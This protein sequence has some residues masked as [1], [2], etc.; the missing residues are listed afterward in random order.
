MK[1][2]ATP[3]ISA[4]N[5]AVGLFAAHTLFP[6]P[7]SASSNMEPYAMSDEVAPGFLAQQQQQQSTSA[8]LHVP[9]SPSAGEDN[10]MDLPLPSQVQPS[11]RFSGRRAILTNSNENKQQNAKT[12]G[13]ATVTSQPTSSVTSP[14][15]AKSPLKSSRTEN[16]SKTSYL[17]IRI[18]TK[19]FNIFAS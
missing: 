6:A 11:L 17:K 18:K 4:A 19:Y 7:A 9:V 2:T 1:V 16:S 15:A 8:S 5:I 14:A 13:A 3:L 12:G 10:Y